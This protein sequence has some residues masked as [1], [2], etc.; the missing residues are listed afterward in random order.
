MV[1]PADQFPRPLP[2]ELTVELAG[3]PVASI[4]AAL[5]P[6]S[7]RPTYQFTFVVQQQHEVMAATI[8]T[9]PRG[10]RALKP[11]PV[12]RANTGAVAVTGTL[13]AILA[14]LE[15][16]TA[17]VVRELLQP[18]LRQYKPVTGFRAG[19]WV[20]RDIRYRDLPDGYNLADVLL[21]ALPGL[22]Q[23]PDLTEV[24]ENLLTTWDKVRNELWLRS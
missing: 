18:S 14:M 3:Q 13:P 16:G 22:D 24:G 23:V 15:R 5:Q 17:G 4:I 11:C 6:G 20:S 12:G 1:A 9:G 8:E 7:Q 19:G 10:A 2:E 21:A